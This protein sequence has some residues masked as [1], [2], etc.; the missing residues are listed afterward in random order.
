MIRP[1]A[2]ESA[3]ADLQRRGLGRQVWTFRLAPER[4]DATF[5]KANRLRTVQLRFDGEFRRFSIS[6]GHA[7]LDTVDI[8]RLDVAAPQRLVRAAA[9]RIGKPTSRIDYLIPRADGWIAYF[10]GGQYFQ[11]DRRGRVVRRIS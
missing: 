1:A 5:L 11:G 3:I 10:K 2:L 6:A 4:I 9:K 8:A 7:G